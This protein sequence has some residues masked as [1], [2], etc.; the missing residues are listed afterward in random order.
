MYATGSCLQPGYSEC[1]VPLLWVSCRVLCHLNWAGRC[2]LMPHTASSHLGLPTELGQALCHP[3]CRGPSREE[4]A[5]VLKPRRLEL[6]SQ[7]SASLAPQLPPLPNRVP[8]VQ[9]LEEERGFCV[10]QVY[11]SVVGGL[12]WP[13]APQALARAAP[14]AMSQQQCAANSGAACHPSPTW[15]QPDV[16]RG[17]GH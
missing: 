9:G 10:M 2:A 8:L 15:G 5:Q 11:C 17:W 1:P 14:L 7:L 6:G 12:G 16:Q 13:L 3:I 4:Q